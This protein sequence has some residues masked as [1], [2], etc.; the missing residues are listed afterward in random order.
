MDEFDDS[1]GGAVERRGGRRIADSA[2]VVGEVATAHITVG[3][4][5]RRRG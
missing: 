4:P 1:T 3:A 5:D 2:A